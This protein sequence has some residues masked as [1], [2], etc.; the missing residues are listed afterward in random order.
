MSKVLCSPF[1]SGTSCKPWTKFWI[2]V[3]NGVGLWR[4][5][6][7]LPEELSASKSFT[8]GLATI[9][10]EVTFFT[11]I[12]NVLASPGLRVSS[13]RVGEM[14]MPLVVGDWAADTVAEVKNRID[15]RVN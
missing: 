15:M 11:M 9:S 1:L 8:I 10:P 14:L 13:L 5:I 3:G 2:L 12:F 7:G 4:T 6:F